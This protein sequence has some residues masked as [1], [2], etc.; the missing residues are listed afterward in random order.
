M[1]NHLDTVFDVAVLRAKGGKTS[2]RY[3]AANPNVG[4][5][6]GSS[7]QARHTCTWSIQLLPEQFG[8]VLTSFDIQNVEFSVFQLRFNLMSVATPDAAGSTSAF[9][10]LGGASTICILIS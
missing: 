7:A 4:I 10:Q 8:E 6:G 2:A 1:V 9:Q 5:E 3:V